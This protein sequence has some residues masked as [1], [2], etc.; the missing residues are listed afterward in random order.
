MMAWAPLASAIEPCAV[1]KPIAWRASW[2][3]GGAELGHVVE[4]RMPCAS[5]RAAEYR[6]PDQS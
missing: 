2:P 1:P 6:E 4:I 3:F 5:H